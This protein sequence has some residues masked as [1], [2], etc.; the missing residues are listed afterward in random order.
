MVMVTD[1]CAICGGLPNVWAVPLSAARLIASLF[2][3]NS[4]GACITSLV[5]VSTTA[6]SCAEVAAE[7]SMDSCAGSEYKD[8]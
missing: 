4:V 5:I 7:A 8:L 6:D 2:I 3:G 1:A